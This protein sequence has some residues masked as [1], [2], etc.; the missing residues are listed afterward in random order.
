MTYVS[1]CF[2]GRQC[3]KNADSRFVPE[4]WNWVASHGEEWDR[5]AVSGSVASSLQMSAGGL[6]QRTLRRRSISEQVGKAR[7]RFAIE[8]VQ[9]PILDAMQTESLQLAHCLIRMD[10]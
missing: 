7:E 2:E 1:H 4:Y 3:V 8:H 6:N 5:G 9:P 10:E